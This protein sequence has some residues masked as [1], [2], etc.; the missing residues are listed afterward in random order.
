MLFPSFTQIFQIMIRL[1]YV[2]DSQFV[3][4]ERKDTVP[5]TFSYSYLISFRSFNE[6]IL[7]LRPSQNIYDINKGAQNFNRQRNKVD[8]L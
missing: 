8:G 5:H 2:N 1:A 7:C 6:R 4:G 3:E